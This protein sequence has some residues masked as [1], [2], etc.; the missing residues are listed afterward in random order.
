MRIKFHRS[1]ART[2]TLGVTAAIAVAC[3]GTPAA[4]PAGSQAGTEGPA[5]PTAIRFSWDWKPDGDWSP[6]LWAEEQGYFEEAGL[7]VEFVAGDGSSAVL[8]LIATGEHRLTAGDF[9]ILTSDG[10][11]DRISES[12]TR[13]GDKR[14][15]RALVDQ[16]GKMSSDIAALCDRIVGEVND[17]GGRQPV[18]DDITLVVVQYTGT[19]MDSKDSNRGVAA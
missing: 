19:T 5:E 3:T 8:P 10:L 7:D 17:F 11:T 12:G 9:M 4:S 2:V 6:I 13:F 18:D 14:L 15:R 1:L 16:V